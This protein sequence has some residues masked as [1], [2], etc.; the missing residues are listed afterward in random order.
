MTVGI[1]VIVD[2]LIANPQAGVSRNNLNLKKMSQKIA[3]APIRIRI[4]ASM[5][6]TGRKRLIDFFARICLSTPAPCRCAAASQAPP[7]RR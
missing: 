3:A 7:R 2:R 5:T 6:A 4:A 1:V